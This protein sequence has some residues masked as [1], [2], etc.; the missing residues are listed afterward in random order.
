MDPTLFQEESMA[1]PPTFPQLWSTKGF[2]LLETLGICSRWYE[3]ESVWGRQKTV[4]GRGP[5]QGE[6]AVCSM[7][8][9]ME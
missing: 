2:P 3:E 9:P 5:P 6:Q 7:G 8:I 4:L 1:P